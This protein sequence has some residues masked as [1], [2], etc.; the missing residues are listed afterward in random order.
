M[1]NP[2]SWCSGALPI[3][4][5][6]PDSIE[7]LRA[8]CAALRRANADLSAALAERDAFLA[9]VAHE[10]RNPMTPILGQ[11][12]RLLA[13]AQQADQRCPD[14]LVKG[15]DRLKWLVDRYIRRATTF[16][17]V[18][19][20]QSGKLKLDCAPVPLAEVVTEVVESLEPLASHAGCTINAAVPPELVVRCERTA[21]DQILDNLITNAIKYGDAKPVTVKATTRNGLA[22]ISVRDRGIGIPAEHQTLIFERFERGRASGLPRAGFGVGLWLVRRLCEEMGGTI[23]VHSQPGDGST[24]TISLPLHS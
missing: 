24:F 23:S 6:E 21:L 5:P 15:L 12:E 11:V 7:T 18:S 13:L 3:D 20:A 19:R 1:S 16:L 14:R 10:L 8:E 17:D 4:A 22:V 2:D 9:S